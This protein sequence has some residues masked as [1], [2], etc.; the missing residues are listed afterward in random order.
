MLQEKSVADEDVSTDAMNRRRSHRQ[1]VETVGSLRAEDQPKD[2][3]R[4][5]LVADVS[6]HGVGLRTTF[7]LKLN[8][9]FIIDIGVGPLHLSSRMR[10]ARVRPLPDGTF[11]IGGE[12]C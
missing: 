12:F 10:V 6:L 3:G 1:R 7:Q 4:Q 5:V 11:E 2:A 9:V 8:E